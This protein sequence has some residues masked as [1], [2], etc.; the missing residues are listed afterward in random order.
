MSLAPPKTAESE[1]I[2][3]ANR[4]E[5]HHDRARRLAQR[6]IAAKR[7]PIGVGRKPARAAPLHAA[8]AGPACSP[9][10]LDAPCRQ[11]RGVYLGST[12]NAL[13]GA[14]AHAPAPRRSSV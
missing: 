9:S 4:R 8:L 10:P 7:L 3:A 11:R 12:D 14:I 6:E 5:S 2:R 13:S 1:R